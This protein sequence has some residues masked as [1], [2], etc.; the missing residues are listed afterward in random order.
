MR[1][2]TLSAVQT[3]KG[4][5]LA[6]NVFIDSDSEALLYNA[7]ATNVQVNALFQKKKSTKLWHWILGILRIQ[8][9]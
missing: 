8:V 9:N 5:Y 4:Y 7:S 1:T 6:I 2:Q 3:I